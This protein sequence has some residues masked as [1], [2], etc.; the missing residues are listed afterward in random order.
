MAEV[1]PI[2]AAL[3]LSTW[4]GPEALQA[5]AAALGE[6]FAEALAEET[7]DH[8]VLRDRLLPA[9]DDVQDELRAR[10]AGVYAATPRQLAAVARRLLGRGASGVGGTSAALE[11]SRLAVAQ[12]GICLTS[13]DGTGGATYGTRLLRRDV[14]LPQDPAEQ[15]FGLLKHA[16]E[17]QRREEDAEAGPVGV[18]ELA[19]RGVRAVAERA[20]LLEATDTPWRIAA[21]P[22][23]PYEI[24]TGSG[25]MPVLRRGLAVLRGFVEDHPRF[26]FAA[27]PGREPLMEAIGGGLRP[28]EVA[29][30][31]HDHRRCRQI[32]EQGN[33]RGTDR[34]LAQRFVTEVAPRVTQGVCRVSRFAPPQVFWAHELHALEAGLVLMADAAQRPYSNRPLLPDLARAT[35]EAAFAADSLAGNLATARARQARPFG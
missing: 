26:A 35:A 11:I 6:R 24:L 2:E 22:F 30:V 18:A 21:G 10:D 1:D 9:L 7:H 15:A 4:R 16:V 29:L 23:A 27:T 19:R 28:G 17:R 12:V 14:P 5:D 20:A 13:Y 33:L 3:D 25:R 32:V 31:Q 8:R 34:D